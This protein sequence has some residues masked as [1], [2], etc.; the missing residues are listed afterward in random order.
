MDAQRLSNLIDHIIADILLQRK[1]RFAA[2]EKPIRVVISGEDLSTLST[3]LNCLA[4]L[5][6]SG[7]LLVMTFSCSASQSALQ[8]ACLAGLTERGIDVLCDSRYPSETEPD[9]CGFY[10]PALSSNSL[11]KIALG[12]RDNLVCH[13]ALHA[14]SKHKPTIM[15]RNAECL[16][17]AEGLLPQALFTRLTH[18][19]NTLKEY[20]FTLADNAA[21]TG[22]A[23]LTTS[24]LITLKDIRQHPPGHP[25]YISH[26]TLITPAARDEIRERGIVITPRHKEDLCIW[27]KSPAH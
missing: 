4:A 1:T 6:R 14:L 8:S 25:L 26:N 15:T 21:D 7:Y 19:I 3:T 11:S 18:Y 9:Y 5:S 16:S 10:F 22:Q 20:G 23:S 24:K 17:G 13:W 27:Q 12:I 2:S